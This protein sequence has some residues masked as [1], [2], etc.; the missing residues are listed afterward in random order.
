[1]KRLKWQV[2]FVTVLLV[3]SVVFYYFNYMT[4]HDARHILDYFLIDMGFVPFEVL[5]VTLILERLLHFQE[6]R[7]VSKK[8]NM[9]AGAFYSEVGMRLAKYCIMFYGVPDQIK[10]ALRVSNDWAPKDYLKVIRIAGRCDFHIDARNGQP[11]EIRRFLS[12]ERGFLLRL[13]ENPNVL[14]HEAFA[15]LLWAV[16][17]LT[18]ELCARESLRGLPEPDY[19]HLG[20]DIQRAYRQLIIGWLMHMQH[21][22]KE[23]PYLFSLAAR[24]NP[25]DDNASV[26]IRK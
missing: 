1:M 18:E 26:V 6:R 2:F 11:E 16:F 17:H 19:A 20:N 3:L 9:V 13:L 24:T 21:L 15:E 7:L 12:E 4:F 8:M 22:S 5:L 14:E 10:S 25:F 23:Y